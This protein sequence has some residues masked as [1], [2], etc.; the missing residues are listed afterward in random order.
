[1]RSEHSLAETERHLHS[2]LLLNW[3]AISLPLFASD[4]N[5]PQLV[6]NAAL[7][8]L[9]EFNGGLKRTLKSETWA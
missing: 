2:W 4:A 5:A 8:L 6:T 3:L 7:A 9:V 1:M